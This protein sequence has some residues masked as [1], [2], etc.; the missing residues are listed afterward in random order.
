[1]LAY[2]E[3]KGDTLNGMYVWFGLYE[4]IISTFRNLT[5]KITALCPFNLY[6]CTIPYIA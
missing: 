5:F 4:N 1:M 2:C 3:D 6:T